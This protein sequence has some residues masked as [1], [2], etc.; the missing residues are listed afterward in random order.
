MTMLSLLVCAVTQLG[1]L[2][3]PPRLRTILENGVAVLVERVHESPAVIV[4]LWI[5]SKDSP[6][7][8][9]HNGL[10]HL[11]EHV[12]ARGPGRDVDQR[13]EKIGG[14]LTANTYR[15]AIRFEVT[16]PKSRLAMA[17]Q[18]LRETLNLQT[19][20]KNEIEHEATI[21]KQESFVREISSKLSAA[22]WDAAY[23]GRAP[24]P[25]G[26][27][28][29]VASATPPMLSN[30]ERGMVHGD[31]L[32]VVVVGDVNLDEATKLAKEAFGNI[33]KGGSTAASRAAGHPGGSVVDIPG[34]ARASIV[35]G[36]RQVSTA[37][38]LMAGLSISSAVDDAFFIYTPS[39]QPALM[40]VGR[41]YGGGFGE[42]V[43]TLEPK[44]LYASG[45]VLAKRWVLSYLSYPEGIAYLRGL[46]LCQ[47][48]SLRPE[49]LLENIDQV[50]FADFA[51]A[52][53][54]YRGDRCVKVIGK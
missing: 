44:A 45:K 10:R 15:D 14:F 5:S 22:A 47:G 9:E 1:P 46:L 3:E 54:G 31:G 42:E 36:F 51:S 35:D 11:L 30:V 16:V 26:N 24:D 20:A 4:D 18:V 32:S 33:S 52:F 27:L 29:V 37:A 2:D 38:S 21:L 25:F 28:D 34:E 53:E 7:T 49:T 43:D 12:L 17:V 41:A 19:V 8:P 23:D 40:V 39:D 13:L 50:T 48:Q 6:E